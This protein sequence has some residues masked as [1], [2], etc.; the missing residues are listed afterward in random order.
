MSKESK[1]DD[2][3]IPAHLKRPREF[4]ERLV[5][6]GLI[7]SGLSKPGRGLHDSPKYRIPKAE[8]RDEGGDP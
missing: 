5:S 2:L 8:T 6:K 1:S 3:H 4:A 7:K